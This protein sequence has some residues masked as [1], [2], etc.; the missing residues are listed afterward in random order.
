MALLVDPSHRDSADEK[1]PGEV[2]S[3]DPHETA[4]SSVMTEQTLL[5]PETSEPGEHR[6][7]EPPLTGGRV[8]ALMGRLIRVL[9]HSPLA[10][11]LPAVIL[12]ALG[13]GRVAVV[14]PCATAP[15]A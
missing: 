2:P 7:A 5:P 11:P 4:A 8:E 3:V 6:L 9:S 1:P 13:L 12:N 10:R 15:L 14:G